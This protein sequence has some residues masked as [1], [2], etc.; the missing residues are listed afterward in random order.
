[1]HLTDTILKWAPQSIVSGVSIK[2]EH[3]S[4]LATSVRA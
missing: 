3:N 4:K 1:M 2:T